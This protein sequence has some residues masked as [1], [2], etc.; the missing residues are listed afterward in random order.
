MQVALKKYTL[1]AFFVIK[2]GK[3]GKCLFNLENGLK[4]QL[5]PAKTKTR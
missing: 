4:R 5:F 2:F 1:L 3:F